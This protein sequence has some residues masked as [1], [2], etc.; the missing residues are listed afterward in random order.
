MVAK[1]GLG[2]GLDSMIPKP[3]KLPAASEKQE[4]TKEAAEIMI[5]TNEIEPNRDQPRKN[6]DE[7]ALAELAESIKQFGIIQPLLLKKR[8]HYYEIVAGDGWFKRGSSDYPG[9]F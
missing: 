6:F 4:K 3:N 2:R 1:K 5:A 8:E 9:I 7:D